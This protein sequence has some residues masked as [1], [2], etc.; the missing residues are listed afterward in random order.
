MGD[1]ARPRQPAQHRAPDSA[2]AAAIRRNVTTSRSPAPT[3]ARWRLSHRRPR[4]EG[5]VV[6][7]HKDPA[8]KR[9]I[10]SK[11]ARL[12]RRSVPRAA[13][14][15]RPVP[16]AE[17][18]PGPTNAARPPSAESGGRPVERPP[19]GDTEVD[20]PLSTAPGDKAAERPSR[21]GPGATA[22]LPPLPVRGAAPDPASAGNGTS[23]NPAVPPPFRPCP[24]CRPRNCSPTS[25]PSKRCGVSAAGCGLSPSPNGTCPT[26]PLGP[27]TH[28]RRLDQGAR[29]HDRTRIDR[30]ADRHPGLAA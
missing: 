3:Q 20:R 6:S 2:G 10:R 25:P 26:E 12:R 30:I 14:D 24:C 18:P 28:R 15:D 29:A 1:H 9:R 5:R 23:D 22:E 21:A 17:A 4:S 19:A 27:H 11:A 13:A 16:P 8:R 7:P